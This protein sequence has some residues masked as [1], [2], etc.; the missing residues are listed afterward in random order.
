VRAN[1]AKYPTATVCRVLGVSSSGYY[2][3][4]RHEPSARERADRELTR[5]IGH[6]YHRSGGT[7]GAPRIHADLRAEGWRVGRKRVARLMRA[8]G[9]VGV[10]RRKEVHTTQ[11]DRSRR[12]AP[13]LVERD[14]TAE[15]W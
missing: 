10:S 6:F 15:G 1:Q 11:R 2:G 7:Y 5:R 13:D 8:A 12:P 3:W 14:F 4:R 9:L